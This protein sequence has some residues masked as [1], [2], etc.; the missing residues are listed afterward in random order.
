MSRLLQPLK[1]PLGLQSVEIAPDLEQDHEPAVQ[2]FFLCG[3]GKSG[4]NW[5]GNLLNLHPRIMSVGEWHF[6]HFLHA[7]DEF[8]KYPA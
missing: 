3:F 4:T 2:P 6:Q 8:T 7:W 1:Q 5:V